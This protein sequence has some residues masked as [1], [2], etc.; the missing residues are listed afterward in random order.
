[1][2]DFTTYANGD[3][4]ALSG[5]GN[6][7]SYPMVTVLENTYDTARGNVTSGDTCTEFIKIPA[8][9][10]VQHVMVECITGEASVTITVGTAADPD[11]YVTTTSLAT[12]GRFATAAAALLGGFVAADTW[13]EFTIAGADLTT[14]K[15]RVAAVV[16]NCG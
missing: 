10:F 13:L 9:S 3:V 2:A 5:G 11:G 12:A 8:G 7:A 4:V 1:M 15:F 14:G 6:A 16:A